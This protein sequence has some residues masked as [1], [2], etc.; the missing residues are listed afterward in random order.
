MHPCSHDT[1]LGKPGQPGY[2]HESHIAEEKNTIK[3]IT[4]RHHR[5]SSPS[6]RFRLHLGRPPT[7][8]SPQ[9]TPRTM[10]AYAKQLTQSVEEEAAP[11]ST[12][13]FTGERC[14]PCIDGIREAAVE[15]VSSFPACRPATRSSDFR[16]SRR[17]ATRTVGDEGHAATRLRSPL[18]SLPHNSQ[19]HEAPHLQPLV[20]RLVRT[21]KNDAPKG[22]T[23]P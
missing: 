19:C 21:S 13:S 7:T 2:P 12:K 4:E 6:K 14:T 8:S 5:H 3:V 23:T 22:E 1:T 15:R 17:D 11:T 16:T 18:S 20:P 10:S 9:P